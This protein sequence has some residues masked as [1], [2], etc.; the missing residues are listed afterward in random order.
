MVIVCP[1]EMKGMIISLKMKTSGFFFRNLSM[2]ITIGLFML[3]FAAGSIG[4]WNLNFFFFFSFLNIFNNTAFI[5]VLAVGETFVLLTAGIDISVGSNLAFTCVFSAF[6]LENGV[7]PYVVMPL[8]LA[9]GSG[10]GALQGFLVRRFSLQPFLVTLSGMFFLRGMCTVIS[11][12]ALA[13]KDPLYMKLALL[14]FNIGRGKI[15]FYVF[16]ALAVVLVAWY[17]LRFTRFG[18][19]IYALGGG[20]QNAMLMGLPVTRLKILAFT[21]SGFCAALGGVVLSFGKLSGDPI[22]NMGLEMDAISAAVIGGTLLSGGVGT[23]VGSMFGVMIQGVIQSVVIFANL[24]T[25]W[26]KVAIAALLCFFIVMQRILSIRT[27][28]EGKIQKK[29]DR[30]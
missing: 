4:F 20:E 12:K 8:V 26:T 1:G 16:I 10:F 14:K 29:P 24:N 30:T 11:T 13:I 23:V 7:S 21:V 17:V 19:G 27:E 18:R 15:Y 6:L 5:I 22:G 28:K 3:V 2:F 25:W 9:I